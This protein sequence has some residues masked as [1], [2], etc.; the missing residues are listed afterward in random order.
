MLHTHALTHAHAHTANVLRSILYIHTRI[1]QHTHARALS[2]SHTGE[3]DGAATAEHGGLVA[4][5]RAARAARGALCGVGPRYRKKGRRREK[6]RAPHVTLF[7]AESASTHTHTTRHY[8]THKITLTFSGQRVLPAAPYNCIKYS[9]STATAA[10]N[11][12][13]PPLLLKQVPPSSSPSRRSTQALSASL[14]LV[15]KQATSTNI[16]TLIR[17]AHLVCRKLGSCNFYI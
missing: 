10:K 13:R 3:P 12:P 16:A 1:V 15:S 8:D 14:P 11:A 6:I 7:L 9:V 2:L 4:R 17:L 5:P